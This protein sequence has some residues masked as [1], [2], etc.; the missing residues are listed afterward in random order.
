M[1]TFIVIVGFILVLGLT[2]TTQA[3]PSNSPTIASS[4]D[5]FLTEEDL[6]DLDVA[7]Q[8]ISMIGQS[9]METLRQNKLKLTIPPRKTITPRP[10]SLFDP[11]S[12]R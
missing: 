10:W 1:K 8:A 12:P 11:F 2:V 5:E 9:Y 7:L 3:M 6:K 4:E